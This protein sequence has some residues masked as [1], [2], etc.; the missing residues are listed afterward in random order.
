MYV[1]CYGIYP[2][3]SMLLLGIIHDMLGHLLKY[4]D[5]FTL[6][7]LVHLI[8]T[9]SHNTL[10][11]DNIEVVQLSW[12]RYCTPRAPG[13]GIPDTLYSENWDH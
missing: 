5:V 12:S 1:C 2:A 6:M 11:N 8:S 13:S 3:V 4:I 10:A 7:S 9:E